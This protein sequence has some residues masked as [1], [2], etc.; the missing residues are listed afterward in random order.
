MMRRYKI[1][2][3]N[4]HQTFDIRR[5]DG[6]EGVV[7]L[8]LSDTPSDYFVALYGGGLFFFDFYPRYTFGQ[9][10]DAE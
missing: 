6:V 8:G 1:I 7:Y 3:Y 2:Y 4:Y 5:Y 10:D 9:I